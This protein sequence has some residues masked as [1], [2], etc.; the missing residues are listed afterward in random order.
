MDIDNKLKQL[1]NKVAVLELV[2]M[3]FFAYGPLDDE[4][5]AKCYQNVAQDDV[6][7][8]MKIIDCEC[9]DGECE[10]KE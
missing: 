4:V 8:F 10:V 1:E 3:D 5:T 2:L 6:D 9:E 7:H